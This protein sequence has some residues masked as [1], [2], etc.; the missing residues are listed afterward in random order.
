[1]TIAILLTLIPGYVL[2]EDGRNPWEVMPAIE[3]KTAWTRYT[4]TREEMTTFIWEQMRDNQIMGLSIA[5]VDDQEVVWARGFGYADLQEG[6]WA[7]GSTVYQIGSISKTITATA[8]M[9]LSTRE[10]GPVDIDDPVTDYLPQFSIHTEPLR[11]GPTPIG[12]ITIRN[13]LTHHSGIPGSISNGGYVR[14][15]DP[16]FND[17]LLDYLAGA[18]VAYPPDFI[19]SYSNI[20]FTLLG[21]VVAEIS[22]ES[23]RDY[24]RGLFD[25]MGMYNSSFYPDLPFIR[26]HLSL[27]YYGVDALDYFYVSTVPAG[28]AHS[29][30]LDMSRYIKMVLADG[31]SVGGEILKSETL[32][33]MLTPKN[34]DVAL[35]FGNSIGLSWFLHD[36]ELSYAGRLCRHGG[37]TIPFRSQLAIFIDHKLGVVVLSNSCLPGLPAE[38]VEHVIARKTLELAL[39][40][41]TGIEPPPA[42]TPAWSPQT[43]REWSELTALEGIYVTGFTYDLVEAVTGGLEWTTVLPPNFTRAQLRLVPRENGWF[44]QSESQELQLEFARISGRD[45]MVMHTVTGASL[46]GEKYRPGAIPESWSDRFGK[47]VI[48]NLNHQDCGWFVPPA[49]KPVNMSIELKEE[50][51]M[52]IIE[53]SDW[54]GMQIVVEPLTDELGVMRGLGRERSEAVELVFA[55]GEEQLRFWTL[56]YRKSILLTADGDYNGDGTSDIA[57][58]RPW[59]GLWAIRDLTRFYFA[60]QGD[61]PASGDYD[62]DGTTDIAVFRRAPAPALWAIKNISRVYFGDGWDSPVPADYNGDGSCDVAVFDDDSGLWKVKDIT[63][64]YYGGSGDRPLPGDY[65]GDGTKDIGIFRATSGLW[66]IR[67]VSR[68]YFGASPDETVPGDY[69]GDGTAEVGIFRATSGLWALRGMS[70]VYFGGRADQPLPADYDGDTTGDMGIF[71]DASGLWAIKS[72]TRVYYGASGD[73]PVTR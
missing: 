26:E 37:A 44:S 33:Y 52:V 34:E 15:T 6:V 71:R 2:A 13:M 67:N 8:L 9:Q 17:W 50:A 3:S 18:Y 1:M 48:G 63:R 4:E 12:P 49:I 22:G 51:G 43:T 60:A 42:P 41:K 20:A 39:K 73:I 35:D 29:N 11:P 68:I 53:L 10:D 62:G 72:V 21:D 46:W 28:S 59:S 69:S 58:F 24:T 23:F 16:D 32:Y 61:L 54:G 56:A 40:E 25:S 70:R 27:G 45:V 36:P 31:Q 30:V 5:L 47:Y 64:L 19:L 66:A 7:T 14:E 57:V 38:M 55:G 65:A